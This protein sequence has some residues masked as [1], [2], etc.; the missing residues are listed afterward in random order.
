MAEREIPKVAGKI[1]QSLQHGKN[2]QNLPLSYLIEKCS[3]R[4]KPIRNQG[5]KEVKSSRALT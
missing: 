2:E 5:P 3:V 1:E 4:Q